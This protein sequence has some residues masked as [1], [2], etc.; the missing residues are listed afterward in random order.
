MARA[1][2]KILAFLEIAEA[3]P[4]ALGHR[5]DWPH[6]YLDWRVHDEAPCFRR[7]VCGADRRPHGQRGRD[8]AR[9][10]VSAFSRR[11]LLPP[12]CLARSSSTSKRWA[13]ALKE[14]AIPQR[15]HMPTERSQGG[16]PGECPQL[17]SSA[18]AARCAVPRVVAVSRA[19]SCGAGRARRG[20]A[21]STQTALPS[22]AGSRWQPAG[23][24]AS[25]DGS[26]PGHRTWRGAASRTVKTMR[27]GRGRGGP[28]GAIICGTGDVFVFIG[29]CMLS[30]QFRGASNPARLDVAEHTKCQPQ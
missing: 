18:S 27:R 12:V 9:A 24:A 6:G 10:G 8:A 13:L 29:Y 23:S 20:Y 30:A 4:G 16:T 3:E 5:R 15:Q 11:P 17:R 21:G 22:W 26:S 28:V 19:S 7:R 14:G 2:D 25:K 1:P